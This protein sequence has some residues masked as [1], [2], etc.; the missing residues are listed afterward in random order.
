MIILLSPAKTLDYSETSIK[1]HSQ[2]RLLKESK[3]LV[4]VLRQKSPTDLQDLMNIS[5][6]LAAQ[7][8]ERYHQ[9]K[10][11]FTREN[12][13]QAVLAFK[14]DVYQGLEVDDFSEEDLAFA[15]KH[16]RILSGLYGLLRPLDLMQA[17]RLEMSTSL[18]QNGSKNLYEFWGKKITSIINEDL[19]ESGSDWVI[20]LASKEYFKSVQKDKLNGQILDIDFKENRNGTY[21]TIAFNAKKARGAMS[22]QIVK[23]RIHQIE[24][25]RYLEVNGYTFSEVRSSDRHYVF[26]LD[27]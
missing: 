23:N 10:T 7:N 22:R 11:P 2:A 21:K 6:N 27:A 13:K 3:K 14:G 1:T 20:N 8:F 18:Q 4:K 16:I 12:A 5:E 26:T 17:Y 24:D 19:S 9:F 15:Q 25:L